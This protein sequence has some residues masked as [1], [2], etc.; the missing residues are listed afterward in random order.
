MIDPSSINTS[1]WPL[2][3]FCA[4]VLVGILL[5]DMRHRW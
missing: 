4:G 5:V 1:T 2:L 3:A